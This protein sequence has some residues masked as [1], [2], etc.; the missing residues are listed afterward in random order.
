MK[1]K[2]WAAF[3]AGLIMLATADT[4]LRAQQITEDYDERM[5]KDLS[6]M[7]NVLQQL[8][9]EPDRRRGIQVSGMYLP[10][11]GIIFDL[12]SSHRM[13]FR[14]VEIRRGQGGG[15]TI[16]TGNGQNDENAEDNAE[17]RRELIR[18]RV[19]E[20]FGN[21]A[22]AIQALGNDENVYVVYSESGRD[23]IWGHLQPAGRRASDREAGGFV[24]HAGKSDIDAFRRQDLSASQFR[25]RIT[26]T[27]DIRNGRDL[28]IMAGIFQS[29]LTADDN[30]IMSISGNVQHSL[31]PGLGAM[32]TFQ[33]RPGRGRHFFT[34]RPGNPPPPTEAPGVPD[35]DVD[36]VLNSLDINIE[37]E[38]IRRE[39]LRVREE[40][41]KIRR[42]LVLQYGGKELAPEEIAEAYDLLE[43][44]LAEVLVDYG[45]TLNSVESGES[46]IINVNFA[47]G[48]RDIPAR[49][50][51]TISKSDLGNL[52][53]STALDSIHLTRIG[54]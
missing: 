38:D 36:S 12:S 5:T 31:I 4:S 54:S 30:Q 3:A 49:L 1:S 33:V 43:I 9:D 24:M 51:M 35:V 18:D 6:I 2:L 29:A 40:A 20:F 42:E 28:S 53:R 11:S 25:D 13:A 41:E 47:R 19:V 7:E 14:H 44:T 8:L 46:V 27:E 23:N 37:L 16:G 50:I 21:Y 52:P 22:P 48:F 15:V 10:G 39:A 26:Y 45:R 34:Q 17:T 32:F